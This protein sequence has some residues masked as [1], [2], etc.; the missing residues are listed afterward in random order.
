MKKTLLIAA[1]A[2]IIASAFLGCGRILTVLSETPGISFYVRT[3]A[4]STKAERD[5]AA[6]KFGGVKEAMKDHYWNGSVWVQ[7]P[8]PS[9]RQ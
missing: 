6:E 2:I 1:S 5:A 8:A 4:N 9:H 7:G 3:D